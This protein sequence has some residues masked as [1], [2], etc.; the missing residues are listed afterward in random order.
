MSMRRRVAGSLVLCALVLAGCADKET[1]KRNYLQ[2]ADAFLAA[3]NFG[4][5]ILAYKNALKIDRRSG[6][7]RYKLADAYV[8]NN[9]L[10]L[11][12]REYIRAADLL[13]DRGDV[14]LKAA[15]ILLTAQQF[16]AARKYAAAAVKADPANIE[17]QILLANAMAGQK[18]LAGAIR[19]LERT[20]QNAP[21][22]PRAYTSLG[23]INASQ[24]N[25]REAEA[26][27]K[28]AVDTDPKSIRARLALGYFYWN[29]QR[30]PEAEAAMD[31]ALALDRDDEFANRM[32][33]TYYLVQQR[34]A[35]AETPLL[36]LVNQ[37]D[38][39]GT[40]TLADLYVRTDRAAQARPL[41]EKLLGD[42]RMRG[43][44]I[45]R[46]AAL[47]Y[48]S[49][50]PA[51][52]HRRVDEG[53]KA[54]PKDVDLLVLKAQLLTRDQRL[55]EALEVARKAVTLAPQSAQAQ[56]TLGVVHSTKGQTDEAIQALREAIKLDP[57]TIGADAHL[58]RLFLARNN[59][60]AALKHG[61]AARTLDPRDPD[62]RLNLAA[63][64]VATGNPTAAEA[65]LKK[66]SVEYETNAVVH[67]VYG[68]ALLA[69]GDTAG[70]ARE[71]DR[72]L[73]L[74][75]SEIR[76][77]T[78]RLRLDVQNKRPQDGR[79]RLDRAMKQNP[80]DPALLMLAGRFEQSV[81]DAAAAEKY[82]RRTLEKDASNLEAYSTLGQLYIQQQ[83]LDQA[84]KEFEEVVRRQPD[85]VPARTMIGMI[86]DAQQK[87]DESRKVYEGMLNGGAHAPVAANN[88]AWI[89]AS[90]GEQ[91]DIALQ[92]AQTAK[93]QMPESAEVSDTL[94][95]VYYKKDMPE[96]AV[97]A[98][99]PTIAKDPRNA[100]YRYHLGLAYAKAGQAEKARQTLQE[101]LRLQPDFDGADEARKVLASLKG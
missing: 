47:D 11:A 2:K 13:P 16:E 87:F 45:A 98:L 85:S 20:I 58:A 24:G 73:A 42:Q 44:A 96:L 34:N 31:A 76:A 28:K 78:E 88:L 77:L 70:A 21:A 59:F 19:E 29:T 72:A 4:D 36:R 39:L 49:A 93:Q 61:Q 60:E 90:R 67:A 23:G 55:D 82:L 51:E 15:A 18:D 26:A 83:K 3:G 66:L 5:A 14:Q 17:A 68:Q 7:A 80:Q 84:K 9:E 79:A 33:A 64:L 37:N 48:K 91:L 94:G 63:A 40:L 74:N 35:E 8:A 75:A 41:Y 10:E 71:L 97:K 6:E 54:D 69:K 101:A 27:F 89:Y 53:L 100:M 81:G 57:N 52:A 46:L 12:A 38:P 30:I 43:R 62:V 50:K 1:A 95:W 92:L 86:L 99:E 25:L 65:E 56:F 22:D 32:L